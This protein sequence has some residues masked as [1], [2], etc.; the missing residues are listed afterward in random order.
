MAT[1]MPR[2][3]G[4]TMYPMAATAITTMA[5]IIATT[6]TM[7]AA[8]AG[9]GTITMITAKRAIAMV[10]NRVP[11][12]GRPVAEK[13]DRTEVVAKAVQVRDR[14]AREATKAAE[15]AVQAWAGAVFK[16]RIA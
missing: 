12:A 16:G 6:A 3:I 2:Y 1:V 13:L 10:A 14:S 9:I 11:K 8:A 7:M 5:I 4:R 15:T